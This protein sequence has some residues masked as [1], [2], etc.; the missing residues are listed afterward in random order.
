M[1]PFA[2]SH[3]DSCHAIVD[4]FLLLPETVVQNKDPF[5]Q[6]SFWKKM[7][8]F[9]YSSTQLKKK[10][11][12]VFTFFFQIIRFLIHYGQGQKGCLHS[13]LKFIV[14]GVVERAFYD[15]AW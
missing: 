6:Q 12:I 10:V 1:S 15:C 13:L 5:F 7:F 14:P 3:G 4:I 2:C 11:F 8:S 9:L